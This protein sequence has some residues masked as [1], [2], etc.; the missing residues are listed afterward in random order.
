M[1]RTTKLQDSITTLIAS[2]FDLVHIKLKF[3]EGIRIEKT[4]VGFCSKLRNPSVVENNPNQELWG[5]HIDF[6]SYHSM[7][8]IDAILQYMGFY[9]PTENPNVIKREN[10]NTQSCEYII[11]YHDELYIASTTPEDIL[12]TFTRQ[13]HGSN[14]YLQ[15]KYIHMILVEEI[16]CQLQE[17]IYVYENVN[18][19]F[20][21]TKLSADLYILHSKSSSY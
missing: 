11:I 9:S 8:T 10:H 21:M 12:H 20:S 1:D 2:N 18:I 19:L 17:N 15:D 13:I 3:V 16:F 6:K 14:I 4:R 7:W 5:V